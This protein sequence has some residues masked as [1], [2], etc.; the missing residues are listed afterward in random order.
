MIQRAG[1]DRS[2]SLLTG[3]QRA[4]GAL[5]DGYFVE[6]TV[7]GDVDNASA[8]AQNEIFGPVLSVIRFH[9][10]AQAIA[11]ANAT[12]YGLAAYLHTNDLR[13]AHR[14]AAALEAGSVYVNGFTGVPVGT[15]F[16]GV[17]QSGFGRMGGRYGLEDFLRPKNVYIPLG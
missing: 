6:P 15:P 14:V 9:G 3:G 1:S 7:F 13:R 4:R 2:G 5:A 17:K 12:Q 8:L 11:L 16:G 10:E